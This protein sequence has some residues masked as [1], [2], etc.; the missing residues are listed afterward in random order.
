MRVRHRGS[1]IV[2]ALLLLAL[3][4]VGGLG[5]LS[6]RALEYDRVAEDTANL[7]ALLLAQSGLED[8][9]LKYGRDIGFPAATQPLFTYSENVYRTDGS[10]LVGRYTVTLDMKLA[11][12]PSYV[13]I[14]TSVG[15]VG[16]EDTPRSRRTIR[17]ELD[18]DP[19]RGSY[20]Q[21]LNY[22]DLGNL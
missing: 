5:L 9:L 12:P 18:L 10:T 22:Q 13:A 2:A 14:I 8:V 1:T 6:Q 17:A 4:L 3:L 20:F 15:T 11:A 21:L 16:A 7:Q 19:D